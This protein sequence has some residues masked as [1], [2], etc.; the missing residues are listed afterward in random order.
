MGSGGDR[1]LH[2]LHRERGHRVMTGSAVSDMGAVI[3]ACG[4]KPAWA[5]DWWAYPGKIIF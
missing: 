5:T 1:R 4:W 3:G 2:A